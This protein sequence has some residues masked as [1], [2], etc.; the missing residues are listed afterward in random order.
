MPLDRNL[1]QIQTTEAFRS[2]A[3]QFEITSRL[4]S[5]LAAA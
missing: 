3:V 2:G 1:F 4:S 5:F